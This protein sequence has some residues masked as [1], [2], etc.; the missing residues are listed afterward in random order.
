MKNSLIDSFS[1][2]GLRYFIAINWTQDSNIGGTK[3]HRK[4]YVICSNGG[5]LLTWGQS[6]VRGDKSTTKIWNS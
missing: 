1:I 6:G 2:D 4:F 5:G 3:K